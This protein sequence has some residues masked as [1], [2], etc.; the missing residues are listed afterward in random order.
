MK[1]FLYN[2]IILLSFQA[3]WMGCSEDVKFDD[4]IYEIKDPEWNE[5]DTWIFEN[6]VKPHNIEVIYRWKDIETEPEMNLIPAKM[7]TIVPFL[8]MVK[9]GWI[10]TYL[11]LCGPEVMNPIFPKQL[12]LLGSAGWN[13][14]G[15]K[16]QGTAEGGKKVVMYE[17]EEYNPKDRVN[18]LHY[19]RVLH[20]E[21]THILN[22]KKEYSLAFKQV[23]PDTY[24]ATW[25]GNSVQ[26]ARALGFVT[27]YAMA[28]PGEDFAE[29]MAEYVTNT[30]ETW[31]KLMSE[32]SNET[33]RGFILKKLDMVRTYLDESWGIDIDRLRTLVNN[34]IDD[35]VQGNY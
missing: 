26:N 15:T 28:E 14:D 20:H 32:I 31:D 24:S 35:V 5:V 8:R 2:I 17:L 7:D 27:P 6:Y 11:E 22:Q 12:L 3:L 30:A 25:T 21:F 23:T 19:I 18:V 16:T 34:A 13:E 33:G 9:H 4:T 1:R 10:D 29:V